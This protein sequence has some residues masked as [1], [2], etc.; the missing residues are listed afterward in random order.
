[1]ASL[2]PQ[3]GIYEGSVVQ[4]DDTRFAWG[5]SAGFVTAA[6][7]EILDYV[8]GSFRVIRHVRPKLPCRTCET[9]AQAPAPSLPVR[10]GRAGPGLLAH[11]LVTKYCDHL[12]LHRPAEI[13]AHEDIDFSRST[14]ADMVGQVA[15]LVRS[16]VDA[17]GRHVMAGGRVHADNT[18]VPVLEP[19]LGRTRKARL[20]ATR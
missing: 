14:L 18:I 10:R 11:V 16:L 20:P 2:P 1:M 19:G 13:Y 17:V 15:S 9:I 12:P 7:A 5:A 6:P 8:P 3:D 4:L